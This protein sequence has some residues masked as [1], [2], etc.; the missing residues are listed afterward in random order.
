MPHPVVGILAKRFTEADCYV[1]LVGD[2]CDVVRCAECAL[3]QFGYLVVFFHVFIVCSE[4]VIRKHV[5][6]P[7]AVAYVS[8]IGRPSRDQQREW[9]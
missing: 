7:Q 9:H 4:S 2:G 8:R 3:G 5:I 1:R 6:I